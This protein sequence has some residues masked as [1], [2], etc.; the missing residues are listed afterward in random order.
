MYVV[1]SLDSR[2]QI[3]TGSEKL[4]REFWL[5]IVESGY[6]PS[7]TRTEFGLT[8]RIDFNPVAA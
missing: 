4:A 1:K 6:T 7:A 8:V 5:A 3:T 2:H